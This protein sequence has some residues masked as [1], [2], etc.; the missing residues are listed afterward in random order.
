MLER[1][2]QDGKEAVEALNALHAALQKE[3][4]LKIKLEMK[5]GVGT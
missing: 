1:T 2:E 4:K 3:F 5:P